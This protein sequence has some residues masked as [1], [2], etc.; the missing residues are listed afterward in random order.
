MKRSAAPSA[1]HPALAYN[2]EATRFVEVGIRVDELQPI[3]GGTA[4]CK[5]PRVVR[6]CVAV[7]EHGHVLK[8]ADS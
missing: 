4:K 3:S 6:A 7:D 8:G 2:R 5:A 1:A